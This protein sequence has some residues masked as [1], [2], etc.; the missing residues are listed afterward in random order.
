MA[1]TFKE[2]IDSAPWREAV[3]YRETWHREYVMS[4]KDGKVDVNP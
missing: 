3:T 4:G 2:L 1:L